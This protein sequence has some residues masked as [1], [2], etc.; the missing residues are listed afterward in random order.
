MIP[1]VKQ[2]ALAGQMRRDSRWAHS[3]S[4]PFVG[5]EAQRLSTSALLTLSEIPGSIQSFTPTSGVGA[6]G[7]ASGEQANP[8]RLRATISHLTNHS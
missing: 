2:H 3:D 4:G 1:S 6:G 5:I 7:R 8:G